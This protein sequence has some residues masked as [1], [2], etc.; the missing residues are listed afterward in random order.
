MIFL[1]QKPEVLGNKVEMEI[2]KLVKENSKLLRL[3]IHF[4][5]PVARIKVNDKL[6]ENLDAC[7]C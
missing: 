6:K 4:E 2:A 3:G 7:K 1:W 5:F